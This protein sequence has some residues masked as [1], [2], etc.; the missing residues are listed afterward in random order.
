M[1][2][3]DDLLQA[4][5]EVDRGITY[6]ESSELRLLGAIL[7]QRIGD[8]EQMRQHVA[9]V[10]LHDVLRPEAEWLLRS[11]QSRQRAQRSGAN[12]IV[13]EAMTELEPLPP[14]P[15]EMQ[16][17]LLP[18]QQAAVQTSRAEEQ[19]S[20][21]AQ[22]WGYVLLSLAAIL[23]LVLLF[24]GD[25]LPFSLA[26]SG[27]T[28]LGGENSLTNAGD[29]LSAPVHAPATNGL[30]NGASGQITPTANAVIVLQP[31]AVPPTIEIQVP[32]DVVNNGTSEPLA[33]T[34]PGPLQIPRLAFELENFLRNS[35]RPD[36]AALGVVAT[37]QDGVLLLKGIVPSYQM[38]QDLLTLT[39]AAE[40][41]KRVSGA[42]LLV[43]LPPTYTVQEGDTLWAISAKFYGENQVELLLEA[44]AD[45]LASAEALRVGMELKI[46]DVE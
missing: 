9:A 22:T 16:T 21:S 18:P 15:L 26:P 31:T 40:G 3:G 24:G 41:V 10:P 23:V 11:H 42:D 7:S 45:S 17:A 13:E 34:T 43:R 39:S 20:S 5:R 6:S 35:N 44:N 27:T 38:R 28:S 8:F 4:L 32:P 25:I 37:S 12:G 1:A 33:G 2:A 36:L 29:E 46:P 14:L 19:R 30:D